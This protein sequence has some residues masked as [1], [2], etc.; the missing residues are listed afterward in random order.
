[1]FRPADYRF[2]PTAGLIGWGFYV[3]ARQARHWRVRLTQN[4]GGARATHF[5]PSWRSQY[6]TL[7]QL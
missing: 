3:A 6:H 1:M 5:W 2:S 7:S 4:T